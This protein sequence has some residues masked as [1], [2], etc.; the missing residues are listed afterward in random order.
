MPYIFFGA[1]FGTTKVS[2]HGALVKR[3]APVIQGVN[4]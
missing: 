2:S 1:R 4:L 3:I